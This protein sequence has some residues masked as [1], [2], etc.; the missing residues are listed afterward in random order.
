MENESSSSYTYNP[1]AF[2][3]KV[4]FVAVIAIVAVVAWFFSL[5]FLFCL[6][7]LLFLIAYCLRCVH[8][9]PSFTGIPMC[10]WEIVEF[11]SKLTQ[12]VNRFEAKALIQSCCWCCCFVSNKNRKSVGQKYL[13]LCVWTS[14]NVYISDTYIR[15]GYVKIGNEK[16]KNVCPYSAKVTWIRTRT[17]NDR[18]SS[19]KASI[20]LFYV[21]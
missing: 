6:L 4:I 8:L 16:C 15:L 5:L 9:L 2:L 3:F 20:K 1:N 13:S 18:L 14:A 10:G 17:T 11:W 12:L 7:I 21:P 19:P